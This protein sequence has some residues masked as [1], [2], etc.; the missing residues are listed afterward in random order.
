[1]TWACLCIA[2]LV[3][4]CAS[5]VLS[6]WQVS[7]VLLHI[8]GTTTH[9][10]N[11]PRREETCTACTGGVVINWSH[12]VPDLG[13][14]SDSCLDRAINH[15]ANVTNYGY[16]LIWIIDLCVCKFSCG[17]F[18]GLSQSSLGI[19]FEISCNA[20]WAWT[21]DKVSF[22]WNS[23]VVLAESAIQELE[24]KEFNRCRHLNLHPCDTRLRFKPHG[25]Y[26]KRLENGLVKDDAVVDFGMKIWLKW[27]LLKKTQCIIQVER[28]PAAAFHRYP[29]TQERVKL[30]E[31]LLSI[32]IRVKSW[33]W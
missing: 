8:S 3:T 23:I 20:S 16:W 5:P 1:M 25:I 17:P 4:H 24:G 2:G 6:L 9:H 21:H 26:S 10:A 14:P 19:E 18:C 29:D 22:K 31:R 13:N 33:C 30:S 12:Y 7:R 27:N 11:L 32:R 28:F 15:L